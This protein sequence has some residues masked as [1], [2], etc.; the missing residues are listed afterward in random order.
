MTVETSGYN[1]MHLTVM[2]VVLADA[3][4]HDSK[5]QDSA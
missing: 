1:K 3:T 2:L 4:I 5:S